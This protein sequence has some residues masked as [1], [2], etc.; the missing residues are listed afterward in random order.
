MKKAVD[1]VCTMGTA[2]C[3]EELRLFLTS[4]RVFHPHTPVVVGCTA[5]LLD[6]PRSS[7]SSSTDASLLRPFLEKDR[8][9]T[10]VPCLDAYGPIDRKRMETEKGVWFPTRHADMMMEKA[11]LME[12]AFKLFGD[13][14]ADEHPTVAFMDC[15]VAFLGALPD[16]PRAAQLALSP[17]HIRAADELLFGEYNGGYV[18]TSDPH[19]LFVWRQATM[20]SRYFD[21]A[22][23]ESVAAHYKAKGSDAFVEIP[24]Q[25]N[26]GYWRLTQSRGGD[27]TQEASRFSITGA[28]GVTQLHY[29]DQ[30]LRSVHTHFF[31]ERFEGQKNMLLFNS[32]I[33]KWLR[34]CENAD[35][36]AALSAVL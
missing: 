8:A 33:L 18:I 31:T 36:A 12:H 28:K 1:V 32:L 22:S 29:S 20:R 13:G 23:L 7:S 6:P 27:M 16:L 9:I 4:L 10:W 26:Y 34:E 30:P 14:G 15:D 3:L 24:P 2:E 11:N 35:Y 5:S 21:Q 19:S 17:H 25:H